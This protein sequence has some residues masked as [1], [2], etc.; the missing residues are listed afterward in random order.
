MRTGRVRPM[1]VRAVPIGCRYS[2]RIFAVPIQFKSVIVRP[3]VRVCSNSPTAIPAMSVSQ[4]TKRRASGIEL[5]RV[6]GRVETI[7]TCV[8]HLR[9]RL[10]IQIL[11][12][13][14]H[15][16]VHDM[17][18]GVG[19][20]AFRPV[21]RSGTIQIPFVFVHFHRHLRIRQSVFSNRQ[22]SRN[23]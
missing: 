19:R 17:V 14:L 23:P 5:I 13:R 16:S 20:I 8:L 10:H 2:F 15:I 3:I 7:R 21:I 9:T 18:I 22:L 4:R 12:S 11:I 6:F 1:P